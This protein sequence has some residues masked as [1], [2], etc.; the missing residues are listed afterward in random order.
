MLVKSRNQLSLLLH[1]KTP[2][3]SVYTLPFPPI[4]PFQMSKQESVFFA[5]SLRCHGVDKES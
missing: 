1:S 5:G 2:L 3:S 4:P